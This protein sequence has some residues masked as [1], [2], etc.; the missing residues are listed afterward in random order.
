MENQVLLRKKN[1]NYKMHFLASDSEVNCRFFFGQ[2]QSLLNSAAYL[3]EFSRVIRG[4]KKKER[5]SRHDN[6]LSLSLQE[7]LFVCFL[8]FFFEIIFTRR[9]IGKRRTRLMAPKI[10][11]RKIFVSWFYVMG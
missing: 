11:T 2:Q 4:L 9:E 10:L 3:R 5:K 1:T 8:S 6:F 7:G